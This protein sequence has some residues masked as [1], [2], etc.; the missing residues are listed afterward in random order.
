MLTDNDVFAELKRRADAGE[1]EP[2]EP[3]FKG[4]TSPL[5]VETLTGVESTLGHQLPSLLFRIYSEV[6]NGGFGDSYGFLGLVGGPKTKTNSTQLVCGKRTA[7]LIQTTNTG[8]GRGT[9]CPS[10][11]SAVL[12][13]I[14]LTAKRKLGQS[15]CLSPTHMK[16]MNRGDDAF[17]TFCPS[18]TA[19]FDVWLRG[20]DMWEAFPP[21]PMA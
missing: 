12:C 18:L 6:Q 8:I 15:C 20:D 14:A 7:N 5:D 13:T 1:L 17:F 16:T 19:Y 3:L 10:D 2:N 21:Q 4:D 9:Y 11:I